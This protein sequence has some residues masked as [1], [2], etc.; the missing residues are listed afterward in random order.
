MGGGLVRLPFYN[1]NN[2]LLILFFEKSGS[3]YIS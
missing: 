2:L 1:C 3:Q